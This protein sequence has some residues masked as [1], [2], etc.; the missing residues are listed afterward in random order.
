MT[1][2]NLRV[3]KVFIAK[4]LPDQIA[5]EHDGTQRRQAPLQ[6]HQLGRVQRRA[7][8]QGIADD[9]AGQGH[10]WDTPWPVANAVASRPSL[11]RPSSS[12]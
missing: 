11:M 8:S 12:V 7:Q 1:A 2:V 3:Q 6:D 10:A 4:P 5:S 9:L